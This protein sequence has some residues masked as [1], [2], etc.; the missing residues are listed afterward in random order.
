MLQKVS[1]IK[2]ATFKNGLTVTP[3]LYIVS[4][5][6]KILPTPYMGTVNLLSDP[7]SH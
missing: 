1:T 3:S 7:P 4:V 6:V 5:P 2:G